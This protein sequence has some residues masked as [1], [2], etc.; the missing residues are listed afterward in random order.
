MTTLLKPF[1]VVKRP[2]QKLMTAVKG[3]SLSLG[4]GMEAFLSSPTILTLGSLF[5]LAI[6]VKIATA[7]SRLRF[8]RILPTR[9]CPVSALVDDTSLLPGKRA[10]RPD[11][12]PPA[13]SVDPGSSVIT[14]AE[15]KYFA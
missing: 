11:S 4:R 9:V 15:R 6:E 12:H 5:L 2:A 1:Q 14:F 10:E 3:L 7:E 13:Q 8:L